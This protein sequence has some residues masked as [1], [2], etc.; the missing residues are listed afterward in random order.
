KVIRY[1]EFV[2]YETRQWLLKLGVPSLDKLIGRTDL[3]EQ[4]AGE[5]SKQMGI[6]LSQILI[7]ASRPKSADAHYLGRPNH[8]FDK[9]LLNQ[10][11]L[12]DYQHNTLLACYEINN[13]DR[14]VGAKLSGYVA[15]ASAQD[16][17]DIN[18]HF[19]GIAGQSFG[20]WNYRGIHLSLQGDANDYVGKGMSG[21]SIR[22]FPPEQITYV[23]SRA[24]IIG[25]TCLY[26]ASGGQL[27]AAG[28]AG[29][30]FA[31][32]N[33][34]AIAV[35]EGVGDHGCEYMT[36]GVV[37]ILGPVGENFAAGMTGGRAFVFDDFDNLEQ[38][39]NLDSV[40]IV[41]ITDEGCEACQ[42]ELKVLMQ[43]HIDGTG[44]RWA[45]KICRN[46]DSYIDAFKIIQA[47]S[48]A[49]MTMVEPLKLQ[50]KGAV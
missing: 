15:Q 50:Q 40:E 30:R 5:S 13:F 9:G 48:T 24:A 38:Q 49:R 42:G 41:N 3:L 7:A 33:S 39:V 16:S 46:W 20:V 4:I 8:P 10:R 26:G 36:G 29:E 14:S 34:G 25:N 47:K 2:A 1:F 6:D 28:L 31:V 23:P 19:Q 37:V 22:I 17:T 11:L 43:Q 18:I 35:V 32:R 45:Q 12:T 27:F 21:G 44:S